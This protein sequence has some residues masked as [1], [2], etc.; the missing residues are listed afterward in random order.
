MH[1]IRFYKI[2]S[3][4]VQFGGALC[5]ALYIPY[6]LHLGLTPADI[7]LINA[8]YWLVIS[9][10]EVITG[11]FA[12]CLS[13][14]LSV[15]VGLILSALGTAIY[16]SALL[17]SDKWLIM[18]IALAAETLEGL[19][20]AFINGAQQAWISDA[21]I[22]E[23]RKDEQGSVMG[24][25]AKWGSFGLLV[26]GAASFL[27]IHAGYATGWATR[28]AF[29]LLALAFCAKWMNGEGESKARTSLKA[30]LKSS[31]SA[32]RSDRSL[33]WAAAA[34][35]VMGFVLPF[36]LTWV[37]HFTHRLGATLTT[38]LWITINI[39]LILGGYLVQKASAVKARTDHGMIVAIG[40]SG[41][42]LASLG[43]T[44]G[45]IWPFA[46][47]LIHEIGRG[48]FQPSMD[49]FICSRVG[50]DFKATYNSLN[51]MISR[52][53]YALVLGAN[54]LFISWMGAKSSDEA[55]WLIAGSCLTACG[56]AFWIYRPRQTT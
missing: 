52:S 14:G 13:R 36:N 3:F 24:R 7:F 54:W 37:P 17:A 49:N 43:A 45:C 32:L 4:L 9:S 46:L 56:I 38:A 2:H 18:A 34:A 47:V 35:I 20:C 29:L 21:L 33:K 55:I 25:A 10:T 41:I 48:M 11:A 1:P 16:A 27:L 5:V 51:S 31:L 15:R 22:H 12:D 50:K 39:G 44:S 26:G 42:G 53:G 23:G 30:V 8:V 40:L 6:L 28:T 19:G